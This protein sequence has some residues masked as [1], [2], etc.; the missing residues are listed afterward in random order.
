MSKKKQ[1]YKS[2]LDVY[3]QPIY[4]IHDVVV[5]I[6]SDV[7]KLKYPIEDEA[8]LNWVKEDE[9]TPGMTFWK[10]KYK[11]RSCVCI[12]ICPPNIAEDDNIDN[13]S[14]HEALHAAYDILNWNDIQL[15]PAT[16]EAYAYMVGWINQCIKNSYNKWLKK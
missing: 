3:T 4:V 6:T 15:A 5:I 9:G 10:V 12:V 13:I 7:S 14:A 16:N 2:T 8:P 11:N 1:Y